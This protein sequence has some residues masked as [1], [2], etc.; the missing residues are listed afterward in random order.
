MEFYKLSEDQ[1][2]AI[3]TTLDQ[4]LL[5][6]KKAQQVFREVQD[7]KEKI[8]SAY[9]YNFG[10]NFSELQ[11]EIDKIQVGYAELLNNLSS[12]EE[13]NIGSNGRL[14]TSDV[15]T[16]QFKKGNGIQ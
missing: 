5:N 11:E 4:R 13:D 2:N 14:F 12:M 8:K 16:E 9:N 1:F 3:I 15:A 6:L 7:L 10:I